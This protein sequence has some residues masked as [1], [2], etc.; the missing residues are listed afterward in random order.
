MKLKFGQ[1]L[2]KLFKVILFVEKFMKN[3]NQFCDM[4][5]ENFYYKISSFNTGTFGCRYWL[6]HMNLKNKDKI[7]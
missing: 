6:G 3:Q 7:S 5:D 4:I 1:K 2:I